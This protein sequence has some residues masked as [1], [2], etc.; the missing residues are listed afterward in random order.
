MLVRS[1]PHKEEH[2]VILSVADLSLQTNA[3]KSLAQL[4]ELSSGFGFVYV[5]VS[6]LVLIIVRHTLRA[7]LREAIG[8]HI[9]DVEV[10]LLRLRF[11]HLGRGSRAQ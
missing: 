9:V 7:C 3:P 2:R 6:F 11:G 4:L 1:N 8:D 10:R 5:G